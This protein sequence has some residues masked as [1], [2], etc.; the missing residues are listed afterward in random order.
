M[1]S[2][3]GLEDKKCISEG[4][5]V[6]GSV[7]DVIGESQIA[8][9]VG[10][11][12][13]TLNGNAEPSGVVTK[14]ESLNSSGVAVKASATVQ[15]TKNSKTIHVNRSL[16]SRSIFCHK[17]CHF[18]LLSFLF[19]CPNSSFLYFGMIRFLMLE[20]MASQRTVT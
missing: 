1:E 4:K 15:Q 11:E 13:P 5:S 12:V 17:Y 7:V 19:F 16:E 14:S 6:E 10:G 20:I 9:I 3:N 18:G 8:D 2:E